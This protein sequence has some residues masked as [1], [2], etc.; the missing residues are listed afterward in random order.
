MLQA[1][2]ATASYE[3][4]VKGISKA[5]VGG[6]G[7]LDTLNTQA[8]KALGNVKAL[9]GSLGQAAAAAGLVP[10]LG[11]AA[12]GVAAVVAGVNM[13]REGYEASAKAA[14]EIA[15]YFKEISAK[16]SML[17]KSDADSLLTDKERAE[18]AVKVTAQKKAEW[19]A[20]RSAGD[21]DKEILRARFE[22]EKAISN[23]KK[24]TAK[25]SESASA[26]EKKANDDHSAMVDQDMKTWFG[27]Q[28]RKEDA[29][30]EAAKEIAEIQKKHI[31][32]ISKAKE[33]A[34]NMEYE[35][36]WNAATKEQKMAQAIK[37]GQ[38]AEAVNKFERSD[39]SRLALEKAR[40]KYLDLLEGKDSSGGGMAGE[41]GR[42]RGADGKLRKNGVII[43]E[44]DAARTDKTKAANKI[45]SENGGKRP[46]DILERIEKLLQP[47]GE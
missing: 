2:R 5:G 4:A 9:A 25:A 11:V 42:E 43:S 7:F 47:K 27:N 28:K 32:E 35:R 38:N 19:M 30:K 14:A 6:G 31:E 24:L 3:R 41:P 46:E 26:S 39:A 18:N 12:I 44:E 8:P 10:G 45:T 36:K 16:S 34:D 37:E 17:A 33:E 40:K 13:I 29:E 20:A 1:T 23:Q 15:A 21:D 22:Y